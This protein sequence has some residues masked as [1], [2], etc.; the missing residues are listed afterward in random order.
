MLWRDDEI[1]CEDVIGDEN[2]LNYLENYGAIALVIFLRSQNAADKSN[3]IKKSNYQNRKQQKDGTST[4]KASQKKLLPMEEHADMSAIKF[5]PI[6]T[7]DYIKFV[8]R[9][10]SFYSYNFKQA[11]ADIVDE[12]Q[13]TLEEEIEL[14]LS[15]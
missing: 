5:I 2:L 11:T 6:L 10:L 7:A 12:E 13:M 8:Q 14:E 15:G 4:P 1:L 3:K 9:L